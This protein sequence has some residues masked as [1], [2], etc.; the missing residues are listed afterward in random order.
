[1][2]KLMYRSVWNQAGQ[3]QVGYTG[4]YNVL[5]HK[6]LSEEH[7]PCNE[8]SC[9]KY[10]LALKAEV[11]LWQQAE[12]NSKIDALISPESIKSAVGRVHRSVQCLIAQGIK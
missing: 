9:N 7:I 10:N 4:Q 1:M 12:G 3:L 6:T 5:L 11:G 8:Y 2:V